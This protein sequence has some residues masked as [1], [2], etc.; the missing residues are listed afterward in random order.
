MFTREALLVFIGADAVSLAAAILNLGFPVLFGGENHLYPFGNSLLFQKLAHGTSQSAF[1]RFG[2]IR[3]PDLGRIELGRRPHAGNDRDPF[4]RTGTDKVEFAGDMVNGI[5]HIVI[6]LGKKE[7]TV[8]GCI[9][10]LVRNYF[11]IRINQPQPLVC[12]PQFLLGLPPQSWSDAARP[13]LA[14]LNEEIQ[15]RKQP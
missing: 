5:H 11:G 8:I 12:L 14:A 3:Y 10:I 15:R 13:L 2:D 1:M 9:E 4:V 6:L 7:I